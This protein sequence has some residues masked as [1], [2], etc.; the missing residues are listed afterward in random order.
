MNRNL[1][2]G[3]EMEHAVDEVDRHLASD[4]DNIFDRASAHEM[5][6]VGW[7]EAE[8]IDNF[9]YSPAPLAAATS[10]LIAGA[11]APA[12]T[13][14]VGRVFE[15]KAATGGTRAVATSD[16]RGMVRPARVAENMSH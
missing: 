2:L 8:I 1:T 15:L 9:G 5:R 10:P 14:T 16:E 12:Y 3:D 11:S 4:R 7:T 13:P 6:R